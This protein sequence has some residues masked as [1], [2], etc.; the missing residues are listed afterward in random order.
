MKD[1]DL[2][3][4]NALT[5][6]SDIFYN[7]KQTSNKVVYWQKRKC[8]GV[9]AK[10]SSKYKNAKSLGLKYNDIHLTEEESIKILKEVLMIKFS[11]TKFRKILK[12]TIG[13][14]LVEL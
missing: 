6:Y 8:I 5:I 1:G 7:K 9:V 13:K 12:N 2:G 11:Q 4:Y 14:K 10:M 3:N